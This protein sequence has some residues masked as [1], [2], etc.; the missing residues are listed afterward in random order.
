MRRSITTSL[1]AASGPIVVLAILAIL[2]QTFAEPYQIRLAYAFFINLVLALG[3]QIF[4]GNSGVVSF[5]HLGFMGIASYTTA[6]LTIPVAMKGAMIPNAPFGLALIEL[7]P[8]AAAVVALCLVL[9][10]AFVTGFLVSRLSGAAAEIFTLALLVIAYVIFVAWIDLTRG[11]RSLYGVPVTAT[12]YT[13]AAVGCVAVVIARL[14]RDSDIGL[15]LRASSEDMLAARAMGV[16]IGLLRHVAWVISALVVALAGI[17]HASFL[18]GIGPNS[19][20][21]NQTFLIMAMI[22]LGGMRSVSGTIVGV[23]FISVGNEIAR[24]LENGPTILGVDLPELFG[25]TGFFLGC[26][27]VATMIWKRDGL[28][29]DREFEN[30]WRRGNADKEAK[31]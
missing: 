25:L 15:Q 26:V 5:G 30:L 22:I 3:L 11:Q 2:I 13:A 17:L 4:M 20:Y 1:Y 7:S 6:I 18:G 19:F 27:I 31:S 9:V 21:F 23:L 12:L 14:F 28:L 29:G 10:V 16:R 8:L 24:T